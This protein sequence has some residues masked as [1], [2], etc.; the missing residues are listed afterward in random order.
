MGALV[1]TGVVHVADGMITEIWRPCEARFR[2]YRVLG[3][4]VTGWPNPA[5]TV[6]GGTWIEADVFGDNSMLCC[7]LWSFLC[8]SSDSN[9]APA[10][11]AALNT[12]RAFESRLDKVLAG[13]LLHSM[14]SLRPSGAV[15]RSEWRLL[16]GGDAASRV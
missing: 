15:S 14:L 7:F 13:R 12:D 3:D 8:A 1:S 11:F 2:S 9:A 10:D 6:P 4:A 5:G 16:G